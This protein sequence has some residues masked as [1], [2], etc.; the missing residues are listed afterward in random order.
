[1]ALV[2]KMTGMDKVIDNLHKAEALFAAKVTRGLKKAGL[3]LQAES[4]AIVPVHLNHLKPSAFTRL[5]GTPL[6]PDVIVGYTAGYA[7]YVHE[8]LEALHGN[9]FNIAY[10]DKI[11]AH[12]RVIKKGKKAGELRYTSKR[13]RPRGENQQA[14]FLETPM[15]TKRKEMMA[16]IKSEI[17]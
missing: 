8:N 17:K 7:V 11:N 10:A 2:R 9:A 15:R 4:Q 13:W 16:I 1:M 5:A 14:K 6:K 12:T 3:F